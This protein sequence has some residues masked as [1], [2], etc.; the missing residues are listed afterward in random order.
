MPTKSVENKPVIQHLDD[1]LGRGDTDAVFASTPP[2]TDLSR[3][4]A[5]YLP[6]QESQGTGA[7]RHGSALKATK[8]WRTR[9][10]H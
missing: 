7:S 3:V 8:S 1:A 9:S 6:V 5:Y 2:G 10:F 4:S